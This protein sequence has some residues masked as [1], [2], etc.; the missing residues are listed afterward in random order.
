MKEFINKNKLFLFVLLIYIFLLVFVSITRPFTQDEL[1]SWLIARDL[2]P[3]GI[4]KQMKY[5]GHSFLWYFLLVPFAKTGCSVEIQ[6]VIPVMSSIIAVIV[7]WKKSSFDNLLKILITFSSGLVYYYGNFARPYCFVIPLLFIIASIYKDKDEHP[8]LYAILLGILGNVH[9]ITLPI[10]GIL[11]IDYWGKY[12]IKGNKD[13]NKKNKN[14]ILSLLVLL[15]ILSIIL[16]GIIYGFFFSS[17]RKSSTLL[18]T[19]L[20]RY[21]PFKFIKTISTD[22]MLFCGYKTNII[23]VIGMLIVFYLIIRSTIK[24]FKN[25]IVFWSFTLFLLLIHSLFW[26]STV[27][28]L[29]LIIYVLIFWYWINK[30]NK[31]LKYSIIIFILLTLPKTYNMIIDNTRYELSSSYLTTNYINNNIEKG[32]TIYYTEHNFYQLLT[33]YLKNYNIYSTIS[34]KYVTYVTWD[35]NS[36][37]VFKEDN[38]RYNKIY[39]SIYNNYHD[40][41]YIIFNYYG[42][43]NNTESNEYLYEE[44]INTLKLEMVYETSLNKFPL[45]NGNL[46]YKELEDDLQYFVIYKI[47]V[48]R[49]ELVSIIEN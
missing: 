13:N 46:K 17:I 11:V 2:S 3:L 1:Q 44:L 20:I 4:I 12:F 42:K 18:D 8:Y 6:R 39:K 40:N 21:W 45:V 26:F 7:L 41:S 9:L 47:N 38:D 29:Y 37:Y 49:E 27:L 14:K 34:D 5:E 43:Y 32:S 19:N 24:D 10:V 48:N 31:Y 15:F 33:P 30:D 35:D 25:S 23:F 36:R 16:Y 28:R 22:F